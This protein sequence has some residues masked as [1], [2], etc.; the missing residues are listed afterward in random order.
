MVGSNYFICINM[1][2]DKY[3]DKNGVVIYKCTF[4]KQTFHSDKLADV[5]NW[6]EEKKSVSKEEK[7]EISAR[8]DRAVTEFYNN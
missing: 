7:E 3:T 5:Q 2:V 1:V 8:H 4:G 6:L